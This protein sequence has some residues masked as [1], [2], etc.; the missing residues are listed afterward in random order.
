[1]GFNAGED[2]AER[3]RYLRR[4]ELV[5]SAVSL[6]L[7]LAITLLMR[8]RLGAQAWGPFIGATAVLAIFLCE[9]ERAIRAAA[10]DGGGQAPAAAAGGPYF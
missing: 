8:E 6:T 4:G 1:M 10:R 7:A 9:Y 5:G 3:I 2:V